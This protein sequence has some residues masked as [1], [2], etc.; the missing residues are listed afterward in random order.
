M[1]LLRE[2]LRAASW[3]LRLAIPASVRCISCSTPVSW[4][5]SVSSCCV[6]AFRLPDSSV[7]SDPL[8]QHDRGVARGEHARD[9]GGPGVLE[10]RGSG[11][12]HVGLRR[13]ELSVGVVQVHANLGQPRLRGGKLLAGLVELLTDLVELR[14]ELVDPGLNLVDGRLRSRASTRSAQRKP[15]NRN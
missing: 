7:S 15:A 13:L 8:L 11:L 4:L 9:G 2:F 6:S 1:S 12:R 10:R 3:L 14:R 5:A